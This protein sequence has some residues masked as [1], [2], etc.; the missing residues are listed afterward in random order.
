MNIDDKLN[1]LALEFGKKGYVLIKSESLASAFIIKYEEDID[2][3]R[4]LFERSLTAYIFY[5]PEFKEE[6]F[7]RAKISLEG[8]GTVSNLTETVKDVSEEVL[9]NFA[10]DKRKFEL[11]STLMGY[12]HVG[13]QKTLQSIFLLSLSANSDK[14][15]NIVVKGNTS[16]GKTDAVNTVLLLLPSRWVQKIGRM[17]SNAIWY[18]PEIGAPILY[19]QELKTEGNQT[20]GLKLSSADDGGFSIAYPVRDP[21]TGEMVTKTKK[22]KAKMFVATTTSISIDSELENRTVEFNLVEDENQIRSVLDFKAQS[23]QMLLGYKDIFAK[24]EL[25]NVIQNYVDRLPKLPKN[26]IIKIPYA[27][28]LI[29]NLP[30]RDPRITRDLDKLYGLIKA[31]AY[32]DYTN[33]LHFEDNNQILIIAALHDYELAWDLFSTVFRETITGLDPKSIKILKA[34]EKLEKGEGQEVTA[35]KIKDRVNGIISTNTIRKF[36]NRLIELGYVVL[37]EDLS[38][39]N[40]SVYNLTSYSAD[41]TM[42]N[43]VEHI[44]LEDLTMKIKNLVPAMFRNSITREGIEKLEKD[45]EGQKIIA[46][47]RITTAHTEYDTTLIS[48]KPYSTSLNMVEHGEH[49]EKR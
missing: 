17:T 32:F 42:F 29:H 49:E 7:R 28:R 22:L 48:T 8:S 23:E 36:L 12:N 6:A 25:R 37:N 3:E 11:V 14:P 21:N 13:D 5:K 39:G 1:G 41:S 44:D 45:L 40:K 43:R 4:I 2:R 18:L 9:N 16:I 26:V 27:D 31:I 46:D 47:L 10:D 34:I 24:S 38:K 19:L 33:R 15:V 35:P 20:Q 30:H